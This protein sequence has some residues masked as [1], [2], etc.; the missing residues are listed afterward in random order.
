MNIYSSVH[1]PFGRPHRRNIYKIMNKAKCQW[2]TSLILVTWEAEIGW[3]TIQ[4]QPWEIVCK[5]VS[6]AMAGCSGS[7][8]SS[9]A[10][11]KAEIGRIYSY[12]LGQAKKISQD[13]HLNR[14]EL[15]MVV[16]ACHPSYGWKL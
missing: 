2:L 11:Q 9:Q 4:G 10:M 6:Q 14:K 13:P 3:V 1:L 8:L 15:D 12:R 16:F 7:S 5:T